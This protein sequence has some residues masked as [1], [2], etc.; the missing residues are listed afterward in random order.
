[1]DKEYDQVFHKDDR[2]Q[3]G[4]PNTKKRTNV[5]E[6]RKRLEQ[7]EKRNALKMEEEVS[8]P[9]MQIEEPTK[10]YGNGKPP[11][12]VKVQEYYTEEVS[13]DEKKEKKGKK[14]K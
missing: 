12:A 4:G 14:N 1:M 3:R 2:N 11:R 5:K 6:V 7:I 10:K 8:V 9:E 13:A